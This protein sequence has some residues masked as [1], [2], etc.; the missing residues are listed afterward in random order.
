MKNPALLTHK[1]T[2]L[3]AAGG[4]TN[5]GLGL[6]ASPA[7]QAQL[8][9]PNPNDVVLS[10]DVDFVPDGLNQNETHIGQNL[11][12]I[13]RTT[14][15]GGGTLGPAYLGL[16]N[17]YS[18]NAYRDALDQLSPEIYADTEIA[19][20]YG[21]FDFSDNLLSCHVNGPTTASI[22]Y[23]GQ[24][25]WV[26]GKGRFVDGA[27]TFQDIGFDETAGEFAAGAQV[28]LNPVWRLGAGLG[29]QVNS[30][31]TDSAAT[32][33]GNQVQ[34]GLSLKYNP[35]ALLLA[36]VLSGAHGW[37]DT[38]RLM[39][40]GGFNRTAQGDQEIDVLQGRFRASYV[41]GTPG[42]YYKPMLDAAVT[43]V[44][45]GSVTET[46]AG[47][48]SLHV[49]G[50]DHTVFSVSPGLELGTEWWWSNG[51]LVRPY[52]R[53]GLSWYSEDDVTV[54]AS[55]LGRTRQRGAVRHHRQL[56]RGAGG[57]RGRRRDD[58]RRG[59]QLAPLL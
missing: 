8:L 56:R 43:D 9:F 46:G 24:C 47:G 2:I 50:N 40:F 25:L 52:V 27:D 48:A 6:L 1:F 32:S 54:T 10:V 14:G 39:N 20:L 17:V 18:L 21:S 49:H 16:L 26:G 38:T 55:F 23:E 51:T 58:R 44:S 19:A 3:S 30:L 36:G 22:N 34:G 29:Y 41:L 59:Q 53:G 37:Y 57:R 35:G 31:T 11:N 5:S 33:D 12:Q 7:L 28:A 13:L 4:T 42:L 45:L 15:A